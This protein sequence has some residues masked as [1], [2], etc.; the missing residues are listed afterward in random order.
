M[1][2]STENIGSRMHVLEKKYILTP[3]LNIEIGGAPLLPAL[4]MINN[5]KSTV[6]VVD[7]IVRH[8]TGPLI[9][10]M[11]NDQFDRIPSIIRGIPDYDEVP[12]HANKII[13]ELYRFHWNHL[14]HDW[15]YAKRRLILVSERIEDFE[16]ED[17]KADYISFVFPNPYIISPEMIITNGMRLLK[18]GG[19]MQVMTENIDFN[20]ELNEFLAGVPNINYT[21]EPVECLP[22]R[23]PVSI[24]DIM[25]QE[26]FRYHT[27]ITKL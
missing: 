18:R 25:R 10:A 11:E 13:E 6:A 20:I 27:E 16:I 24:Y 2:V 17:R 5:R 21:S 12:F 26:P 7:P 19:I 23:L 1:F 3:Q 9:G 4:S 22:N 15:E 8:I 14:S